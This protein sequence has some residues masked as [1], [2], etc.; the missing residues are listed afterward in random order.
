MNELR[1]VIH[2]EPDV[3]ADHLHHSA[4]DLLAE[5]L[6]ERAI[7]QARERREAGLSAAPAP[8]PRRPRAR[9]A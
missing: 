3:E 1:L 8:A 4:L 2:A 5:A 6:A 9:R 7:H